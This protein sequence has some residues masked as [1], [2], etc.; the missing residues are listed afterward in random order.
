MSG[1]VTL[2]KDLTISGGSAGLVISG[3]ISEDGGSHGIRKIVAGATLT[4]GGENTYTGATTISSGT[5]KL[6]NALAAQHSTIIM[7]RAGTSPHL[8]FGTGIGTF[9]IGGLSGDTGFELT[10]TADPVTL[11]VGGNGEDTT[12]SGSLS[13]DGGGLVK[14]GT[15]SATLSGTNTYTGGT[16]V[17]SGILAATKVAALPQDIY[18]TWTDVTVEGGG[19]LAV[20]VG[21]TGEWDTDQLDDL[22]TSADFAS[23]S[24][25]AID[26][27]N[28]SGGTFPHAYDINGDLGIMK[29]GVGT[30]ELSGSNTYAGDTTIMAGRLAL[31]AT[32]RFLM[33]PTRATSWSTAAQCSI[34]PATATRSTD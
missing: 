22:L 32:A 23:D 27:T 33:E 2:C 5:I 34:W 26:T 12:Y 10:D 24:T 28:A 3:I 16:T 30:L 17:E 29:L 25:I 18:D 13:G 8:T 14:Q 15:G 19:A 20:N 1:N 11:Q 7:N 9:T 21:D 4:L 6:D 31:G